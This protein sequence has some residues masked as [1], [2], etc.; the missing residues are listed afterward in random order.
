M[1]AK[2]NRLLSLM[3]QQSEDHAV[4]LLDE[5]GTVTAW[6]MGA[7]KI[8]GHRAEDM[9]GKPLHRLFTSEDQAAG[10]PE[11]ELENAR[12]TG[13]GEDDRW[14]VRSDGLRFWATGFVQCL[15]DGDGRI[16]GF[17][18]VLRDRTDLRGMFEAL[19]NRAELLEAE[20]RRKVMVLGTLAHELRN[21]LGAVSNAIQLI[22]FAYPNDDKLAYAMQILKRQ[23]K[24]VTALIEDL[25]EVVRARTG[26]AILHYMPIEMG[27]LL[28]DVLETL[29]STIQEKRQQVQVLEPPLGIRLEGDELKLKQVFLNLL[30]NAS[31]FSETGGEI[32]VKCTVE[33]DEAVIRV[34]DHG[35]GISPQLLP[36]VFDL[37]AQAH[38][39]EPSPREGL[40]LGLSIVKEYVQLHGGTVQVRS[41]GIGRGSEFAV[42]LPLARRTAPNDHPFGKQ[43]E[44]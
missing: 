20:D 26:K 23:T 10:V 4:I 16:A 1:E 42:H 8:F 17:S 7:Q 21:P 11:S 2:A 33:A 6:L 28:A 12:R 35:R 22:D 31:K 29:R 37:L 18:K 25:L 15:R 24:H 9:I 34:E 30:Q 40:G 13:T 5:H 44:A 38:D 3:Y 27:A 43:R 39:P 41:E 19:R 36:N 32:F 14:M